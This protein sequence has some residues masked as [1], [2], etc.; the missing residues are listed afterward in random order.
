MQMLHQGTQAVPSE[1]IGFAAIDN[2][3]EASHDALIANMFAQSK[4]LAFGL[5]KDEIKTAKDAPHRLMP[6]NRPSTTLIAKTLDARTLGAL[7]AM[8]E[9]RVFV[10]GVIT[11]IN[12]F[13]QWGV[14][15]GKTLSIEISHQ[16][17]DETTKETSQSD[18]AVNDSSTKSLIGWYRQSRKSK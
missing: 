18:S 5:T 11:Q 10:F 15:L 12:S 7:I 9:H 1:F 13:D 14:E 4:A 8:Y 2:V 16:I 17:N 6:G 3:D